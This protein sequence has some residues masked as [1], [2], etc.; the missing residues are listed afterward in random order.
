MPLRNGHRATASSSPDNNGPPTIR[1]A[2]AYLPY[3]ARSRLELPL[4]PAIARRVVS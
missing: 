3:M 1:I 4:Q 2:A